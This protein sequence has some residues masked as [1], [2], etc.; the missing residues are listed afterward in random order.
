MPITFT[1]KVAYHG[2]DRTADPDWQMVPV[3]GERVLTIS[4][5]GKLAMRIGNPNKL[6][7]VLTQSGRSTVLTLTGG[8]NRAGPMWN[9][10]AT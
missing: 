10:C 4:G 9:G 3:K 5:H 2:F 1:P 6:K 8:E 7:A